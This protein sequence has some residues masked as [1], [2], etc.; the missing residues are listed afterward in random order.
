M[1][2]NEN[3]AAAAAAPPSL[4]CPVCSSCHT[5]TSRLYSSRTSSTLTSRARL[6]SS[7]CDRRR[8]TKLKEVVTACQKLAAKSRFHDTSSQLLH[9]PPAVFMMCKCFNSCEHTRSPWRA[10]K[11]LSAVLARFCPRPPL[12]RSP[13]HKRT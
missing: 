13:D 10:V 8:R 7:G 4:T 2:L 9:L 3:P 1:V 11:S 6:L 12:Q 5:P